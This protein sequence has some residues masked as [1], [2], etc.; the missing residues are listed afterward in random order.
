MWYL[1]FAG[2]WVLLVIGVLIIV[3]VFFCTCR[4]LYRYHNAGQY[5]KLRQQQ[6]D[7]CGTIS[8]VAV[9]V[10]LP[11]PPAFGDNDHFGSCNQLPTYAAV[12]EVCI[13][14]L[15]LLLF[16]CGGGGGGGV[17]WG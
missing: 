17:G 8:H 12:M 6:Q 1:L 15:P 13:F 11:P 9:N 16:L 7:S 5:T 3:G 4:Q 14:V 10:N 2:F